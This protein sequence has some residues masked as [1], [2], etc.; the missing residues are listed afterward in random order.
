MSA[1]S[2]KGEMMFSE[3]GKMTGADC[4]PRALKT[5]MVTCLVYYPLGVS[6]ITGLEYASFLSTLSDLRRKHGRL[7]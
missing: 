3:A 5:L 4:Y 7:S 6:L 2:A 1:T